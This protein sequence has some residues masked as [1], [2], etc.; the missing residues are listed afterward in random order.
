[1][2][3]RNGRR[4]CR[5]MQG[6]GL[7]DPSSISNLSF[8]CRSDQ[9]ITAAGGTVSQWNDLS[10]NGKHLA[11]AVGATQP[12]YEAAT[13]PNGT[14]SVYWAGAHTLAWASTITQTSPMTVYAVFGTT[15]VAG[16]G[17]RVFMQSG[18]GASPKLYVGEGG[19][20]QKPETYWNGTENKLAVAVTVPSIYR[21]RWTSSV[22][23][24]CRA[25]GTAEVT[26]AHAQ[27]SLN[28][29]TALGLSGVQPLKGRVHE[30]LIYAKD[31]SADED[32][33]LTNYFFA[34]YGIN[35]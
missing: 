29:F 25:T 27:A 16:D 28:A 33:K 6:G 34:R 14:P 20:G 2:T 10:G 23:M 3:R 18:S 35:A 4:S 7:S 21:W 32:A 5:A 8:W 19:G 11:N 15:A 30:L 22:S 9:G 24:G 12:A 13:G 17:F 1:M 31:I 26:T